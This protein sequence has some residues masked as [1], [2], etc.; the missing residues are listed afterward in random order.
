MDDPGTAAERTGG[1]LLVVDDEPQLAA[2]LCETLAGLGHAVRSA[3]DGAEALRLLADD[4]A[5]VVVSDLRMP[6]MGGME[7]LEAAAGRG[8]DAD[9]IFLTGYGTVEN[10][11]E[12]MRLGAA[13]YLLKPFRLDALAAAVDKALFEREIRQERR[14]AAAPASLSSLPSRPAEDPLALLRSFLVQAREIFAPDGLA[15]FVYNGA[16]RRTAHGRRLASDPAALDWLSA[17][18]GRLAAEGR[19]KLLEPR[20]LAS[21]RGVPGSLRESWVMAAPVAGGGPGGAAVVLVRGPQGP[22]WGSQDLRML[23]ALAAHASRSL[24]GLRACRR[25]RDLNMEVV[26]SH[27]RAVEAKDTYTCGHSERVAEYAGRLGRSL[28][29]AESD[30][31][32]LRAA[33]YLHDVGKIGVPDRVLAKPGRLT[34]VEMEIMR[35]HPA[36][37]REILGRVTT[38]RPALPAIEHHHE[39]W[40]GRGY[41]GGLAGEAI[42]YLAR[43]VSVVD[44]Y[45]AITSERAYQAARTDAEARRILARGAG[46][47]WDPAVV[48][49]WLALLGAE[50]PPPA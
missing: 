11:V 4:P 14:R 20:L 1:R 32:T 46:A 47:Q 37:G 21:A 5:Q 45:E 33:G 31:E 17:L 44:A 8:L 22:G 18:G 28:G 12:C 43:I 25:L 39:R 6:R 19:P 13:D 35:R 26:L 38:L 10:A 40:D 36:L 2:V 48:A 24:E 30:R 34:E 49:A 3:G 7:L 23:T 16:V 42:P 29:L 15:L 27:V 41:P 9:F 50:G